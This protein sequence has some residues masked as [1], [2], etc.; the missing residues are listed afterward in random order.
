MAIIKIAK[1]MLQEK[2]DIDF[3]MKMTGLKK[4]QF[5]N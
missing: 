5:M 2:V 4:E 1:K 3:I